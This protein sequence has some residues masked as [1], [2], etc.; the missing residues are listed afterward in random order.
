MKFK[1]LAAW[2]AAALVAAMCMGSLVGCGGANSEDLIRN[3]VTEEFESLKNLDD[4]AMSE[5]MEGASM[6]D[7]TALEQYGIDQE[8]YLRSYLE[9]FD[10]RI[11]DVTVDGDTAKVMVVLTCKSASDIQQA[12]TD[13][14]SKM[15]EDA[16]IVDLDESALN[17]KIGE[18]F[19]EA[20]ASVQPTETESIE[21]TYELSGNTWELT[22][23]SNRNIAAAMF[24]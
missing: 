18:I 13:S 7:T 11:D 22:P 20:I 2:G 1:K 6:G 8:E 3:A 9:G 4:A 24:A 10:Y 12:I 15:V 23:E 5:L 17:S 19:M 21:L 16:S 14:A